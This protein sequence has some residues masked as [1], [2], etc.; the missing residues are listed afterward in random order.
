MYAELSKMVPDNP[1]FL[2]TPGP[3]STSKQVR[4]SLLYDMCTWDKDFTDLTQK[5]RAELCSLLGEKASAYTCVLMQGS[6]TFSVEAAIG[7]AM[8]K[9]G[10]LLILANGHYGLRMAKI[11]R[12]LG[13]EHILLDF[14]EDSPVDMA[15]YEAAL[16]SDPQIS[17]VAV[18]HVE[19]STGILNPAEK[20]GRIAKK[21]G[22]VFILDAMSSFGGLA[23][24][25]SLTGADFIIASS[26]KCIQGIPGIGLILARHELMEQ[27]RGNAR[28]LSL[29]LYGQW[30]EMED[31]HGKWRYTAPT[32]A[33]RALDVALAELAAEGGPQGRWQ[34]LAANQKKLVRGMRELGFKTLLPDEHHSPIITTFHYHDRPGFTF[35]KLYAGLKEKGFII[36][37]GKITRADTFRLGNIGEVSA[38]D[39]DAL[40]AAMKDALGNI[41]ADSDAA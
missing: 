19:T 3:L 24:D 10:K 4:A 9:G 5:V 34:R 20:I 11:A 25:F 14:G 37:P 41:R 30:K 23:D 1:Y 21:A 16:Q 13:I 35:E 8:P 31:K 26:N 40:L 7:S 38:Q 39:I 28:S 18:V 22:K 2:L 27:I 6:G 29:D 15:R 33:L 17:H 12:C 32:H 36:Y